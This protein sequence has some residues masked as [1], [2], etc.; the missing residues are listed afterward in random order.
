MTDFIKGNRI[1]KYISRSQTKSAALTL[2]T[3]IIQRIKRGINHCLALQSV[4]SQR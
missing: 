2:S 3:W 4:N 1:Q